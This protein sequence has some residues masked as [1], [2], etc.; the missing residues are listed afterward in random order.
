MDGFYGIIRRHAVQK[1]V[2]IAV[3]SRDKEIVC[4]TRKNVY[5]KTKIGRAVTR[6]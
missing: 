4:Y 3:K 5:L 1:K 2:G 6:T